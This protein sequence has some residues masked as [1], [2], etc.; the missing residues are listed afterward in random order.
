MKLYDFKMAPNP[1]RV[2]I[3]AAEKGLEIETVQIDL[4]ARQSRT[5]EFLKKNPSGR[6]PVLE[7]DDG[8]CIAESVAI[9]RY[10]DGMRPEPNLMGRDLREQAL[11]EMWNRRMEQELFDN[12]DRF[13]QNT[14]EIFKG[15]FPQFP[16]YAELQRQNA[17]QRLKR[18]D[19]E[20][21]GREFIAADRYTIADITALVAIDLFTALAGQPFPD[22]LPNVK[23][24]YDAVSSRPSA[25]A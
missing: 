13:F 17:L 22:D 5:P 18:M 25:K 21:E 14:S 10:L 15:R 2:R 1:R 20:L 23:R 4:F 24:W 11:L 8:T 12:I 16:E 7:L 3:F 19:G 9:C 6:L